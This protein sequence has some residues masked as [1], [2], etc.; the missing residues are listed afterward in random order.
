MA[1][2]SI[3]PQQCK[4]RSTHLLSTPICHLPLKLANNPYLQS[5]DPMRLTNGKLDLRLPPGGRR[6]S[7]WS[8]RALPA[9][10]QSRSCQRLPQHRILSSGQQKEKRNEAVEERWGINS[11]LAFVLTDVPELERCSANNNAR[12]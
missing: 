8:I 4:N 2:V 7:S 1:A 5:A 10:P 6:E 3:N 12:G 11:T 9:H